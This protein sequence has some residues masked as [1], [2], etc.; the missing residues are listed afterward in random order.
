MWIF[1]EIAIDEVT[2]AFNVLSL[3][4]LSYSQVLLFDLLFVR[5]FVFRDDVSLENVSM[6]VTFSFDNIMV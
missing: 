3:F 1:L 5:L 6:P 2:I 4:F